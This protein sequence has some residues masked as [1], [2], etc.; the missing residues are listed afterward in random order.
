M[1]Q[2]ATTTDEAEHSAGAS[3]A[4]G[5]TGASAT[6]ATGATGAAGLAGQLGALDDKIKKHGGQGLAELLALVANQ[7]LG[8]PR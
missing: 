5:A 8:V 4:T 1:T 6:G 2:H 3:G 7:F